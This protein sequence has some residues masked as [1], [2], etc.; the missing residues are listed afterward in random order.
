MQLSYQ[1]NFI[2]LTFNIVEIIT[3]VLLKSWN[4]VQK[5]KQIFKLKK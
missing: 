3:G 4:N 5:N 2:L 1:K